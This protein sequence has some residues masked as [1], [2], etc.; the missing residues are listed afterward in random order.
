M[1]TVL[2]IVWVDGQAVS[3]SDTALAIVPMFHGFFLLLVNK[4]KIDAL[5]INLNLS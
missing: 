1:C 3:E 5:H 2:G 4:K